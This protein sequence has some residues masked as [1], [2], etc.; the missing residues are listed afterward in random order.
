MWYK[1]GKT[2]LQRLNKIIYLMIDKSIINIH[3]SI[4]PKGGICMSYLGS[5]TTF[6]LFSGLAGTC[7]IIYFIFQV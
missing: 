3:G 7:A 2:V 4:F 6:R 1:E 5:I